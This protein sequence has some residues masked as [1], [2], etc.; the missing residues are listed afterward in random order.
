[1]VGYH[2]NPRY[3]VY[4]LKYSK[5]LFILCCQ[6]ER[7]LLEFLSRGEERSPLK[8][9]ICILLLDFEYFIEKKFGLSTR[10]WIFIF[11]QTPWG[12]HLVK[13]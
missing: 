7:L 8:Y 12:G 1:M 3:K 4:N 2:L 9:I 10:V 13:S 11:A 5:G 6:D